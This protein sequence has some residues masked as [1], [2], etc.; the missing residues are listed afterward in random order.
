MKSV[1]ARRAAVLVPIV[2][3]EERPGSPHLLF[4]KRSLHLNNHKGHVS[5]PGGRCEPGETAVQTALRETTEEIA[6]SSDAVQVLGELDDLLSINGEIVTPVVGHVTLPLSLHTFRE[7]VDFETRF[8]PLMPSKAEVSDIMLIPI[9]KL[10]DPAYIAFEDLGYRAKNVPV[11]QAGR[12]RV[13]GLTS[14][15]TRTFLQAV[16]LWPAGAELVVSSQKQN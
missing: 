3:V 16:E 14:F 6:L 1:V 15:I 8:R 9:S 7:T 2:F 4:T 11:F 12:H 13:W 10:V 5:F